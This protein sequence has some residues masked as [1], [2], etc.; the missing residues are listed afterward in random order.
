MSLKSSRYGECARCSIFKYNF[1]RLFCLTQ[2][3]AISNLQSITVLPG[4]LECSFDEGTC[5][6]R[7]EGGQVHPA[8][9]RSG[10][11]RNQSRGTAGRLPDGTTIFAVSRQQ[12]MK[13]PD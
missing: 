6:E 7:S 10:T 9:Y 13:H 5:P 8:T 4:V 12:F 3:F 11:P 1:Q 2:S